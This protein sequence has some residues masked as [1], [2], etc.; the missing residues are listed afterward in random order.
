[1]VP[2]GLPELRID[3]QALAFTAGISI[4]T[5]MAFGLM[6]AIRLAKTALAARGEIGQKDWR[7]RDALVAGEIAIALVLV[8]GSALL[9]KTLVHMRAVDPG[10][11]TANVLTASIDAPYPK[12]ADA[13]KR[14]R[15]YDG[16][17]ARVRSIA[18][19]KTAGL[20]SDLPY[21]SRGNT[22]GMR[23]EGKPSQ[24]GQQ[25]DALFRLVS[26]GYL[27]T[28]GARLQE[29][30]LLEENDREDTRPVAVVSESLARQY[31]PGK[32]AIGKR[33]DTGT[34]DGKPLWMTV[35]G[36]VSD[37]R[38]RGLDLAAKPAVY[39]PYPQTTI[40]FFQPSEI[41]VLTAQAPLGV[42]KELQQAVWAVDSEQPVTNVR[43][44]S[45][46]VDDELSGRT[47]VLTLL[48]AFA[49]LAL[50]LAAFGIYSVLSYIVSKRRREIGLRMAIGASQWD[51]VAA[52]G[53]HAARLTAIGLGAGVLIAA[54]TT[55]LLSTL[56]YGVSPLDVPAFAAV[57]VGLA[58]VALLASCIPARRAALV[59]P[60]TA[61]REES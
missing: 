15:F 16:V 18:G 13:G 9:I 3:P 26:A 61:L 58:L 48:G 8:T 6:P 55:R 43:P 33:I 29:G 57:T 7:L 11:R 1:L 51:V 28:V 38:E 56:L 30:R 39:V 14:R 12:Y 52:I 41:A 2:A 35:V 20:T 45:A 19:V 27:E 50:L 25:P 40:G 37:I 24:I 5:G 32:S 47:E 49:A 21:T 46:I 60:M 54:A 53:G 59:D 23:V 44:M 42:A 36:V 34:G 10:F 31:W 17:L 4:A 22:M